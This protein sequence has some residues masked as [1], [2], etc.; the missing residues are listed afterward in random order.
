MSP[1]RWKPPEQDRQNDLKWL[2]EN[3]H[4]LYPAALIGHEAK[5]RGALF[6]DTLTVIVEDD[7]AGN[8]MVY[9]PQRDIAA[10]G[11]KDALRMVRAYDP[12]REFVTVLLKADDKESVYRIY[13]PSEASKQ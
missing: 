5:G 7:R 6:V 2:R 8:P 11:D 9:V 4:V 10:K 12:V 1:E 3:L 13:V